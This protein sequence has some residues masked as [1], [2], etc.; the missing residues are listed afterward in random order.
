MNLSSRR[1]TA[2]R[3][4][5]TNLIRPRGLRRRPLRRSFRRRRRRG[6]IPPEAVPPPSHGPRPRCWRRRCRNFR[7]AR[8]ACSER[9]RAEARGCC[10][11]PPP[12]RRLRRWRMRQ[13]AGRSPP[14]RARAASSR[15]SRVVGTSAS[16]GAM[17][18][19]ET[20]LES[21]SA[22]PSRT[23]GSRQTTVQ[24]KP[25]YSIVVYTVPVQHIQS[26]LYSCVRR[27]RQYK[28]RPNARIIT[29]RERGRSEL[30]IPRLAHRRP[31]PL[32]RAP[33]RVHPRRVGRLVVRWQRAV[34][35]VIR[36]LLCRHNH[37]Q[38][39]EAR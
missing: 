8:S 26:T 3:I 13:A 33:L 4:S 9:A 14:D 19:C 6:C 25:P 39:T 15:T 16:A 5:A 23:R 12:I 31:L 32:A 17:N 27:P 28:L 21:W 10:D 1:G 11:A 35:D 29:S 38:G 36:H 7:R 34:E 22:G 30:A 20:N 2:T 24:P 18:E 37:L